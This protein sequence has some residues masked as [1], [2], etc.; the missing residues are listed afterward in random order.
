MIHMPTEEEVKQALWR[1]DDYKK[2]LLQARKK[3]YQGESMKTPKT[4]RP[5]KAK[6]SKRSDTKVK[7]VYI[8]LVNDQP[9]YYNGEQI[10]IAEKPI[11]RKQLCITLKQVRE[12]QKLSNQWRQQQSFEKQKYS[13]L[14]LELA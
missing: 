13:Y 4:K 10:V 11:S 7:K 9:G 8:H 5:R 6:K 14:A 3:D 12:Q 2:R 1:T